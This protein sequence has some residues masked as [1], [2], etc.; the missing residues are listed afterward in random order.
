MIM[1]MNR[2]VRR[3]PPGV[4]VGMWM[5]V[6]HRAVLMHMHVEVPSPP[7]EQKPPR[8][9]GNDNAD[10]DF[11]SPPERI[12]ELQIEK[13]ERYAEGAQSRCVTQSPGPAQQ[14]RA[15]RTIALL[16]EQEGRNGG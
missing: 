16:V 11:G 6:G 9:H 3:R 15:A 13:Y 4:L 5:D 8:Q 12:R 7:A 14:G 1:T 2:W 10:E